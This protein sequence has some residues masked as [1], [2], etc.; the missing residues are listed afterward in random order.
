MLALFTNNP[1]LVQGN[2]RIRE[3]AASMALP[4]KVTVVPFLLFL[5]VCT[6]LEHTVLESRTS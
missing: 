6:G 3:Q 5:P 1:V 2:H 4:G